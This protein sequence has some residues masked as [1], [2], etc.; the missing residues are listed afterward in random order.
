MNLALALSS[1]LSGPA[2]PL[3]SIERRALPALYELSIR[4]MHQSYNRTGLIRF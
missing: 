4:D 3:L 1:H 2:D